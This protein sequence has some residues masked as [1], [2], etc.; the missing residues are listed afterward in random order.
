VSLDPAADQ[1]S[2]LDDALAAL[3]PD[4]LKRVAS[5]LSRGSK[6]NQQRAEVIRRFAAERGRAQFERFLGAFLT[7]DGE[8]RARLATKAVLE[9]DPAAGDLLDRFGDV[10]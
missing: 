1:Q 5:A 9:A 7:Q 4:D 10:G 3:D 2:I 6:E 8:R